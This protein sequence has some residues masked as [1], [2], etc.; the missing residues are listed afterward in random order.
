M[1]DMDLRGTFLPDLQYLY[2]MVPKLHSTHCRML[3]DIPQ[4]AV[5]ECLPCHYNC[6]K[7]IHKLLGELNM[8]RTDIDRQVLTIYHNKV[9]WSPL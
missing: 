9:I 1:A 4:M 7:Y 3:G 5:F 8:H 2:D 6:L